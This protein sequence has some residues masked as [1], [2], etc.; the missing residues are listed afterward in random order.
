[1]KKL[2]VCLHTLFLICF[3]CNSIIEAQVYTPKG[4]YV[5]CNVN[6][7]LSQSELTSLR[8]QD[9]LSIISNYYNAKIMKT[10][11]NRSRFDIFKLIG[12]PGKIRD[13]C[14]ID[15]MDLLLIGKVSSE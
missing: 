3:Y 5:T 15:L 8:N 12:K 7:E 4:T 2:Y 11:I 10:F 9:S 13:W 6:D 14:I 1:M